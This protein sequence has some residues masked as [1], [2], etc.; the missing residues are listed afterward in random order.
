[1]LYKLGKDQPIIEGDYYVWDKDVLKKVLGENFELFQD[2][3]SVNKNGLWEEKNYVL[4]RENDDD[5]FINYES[6]VPVAVEH[7]LTKYGISP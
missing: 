4:K 1:M 7:H 6:R 3:F 5:F 2:Y